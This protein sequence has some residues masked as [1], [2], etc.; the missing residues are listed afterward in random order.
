MKEL[1]LQLLFAAHKPEQSRELSLVY[2][3]LRCYLRSVCS[4][5]VEVGVLT[6]AVSVVYFTVFDQFRAR[7]QL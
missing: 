2:Y 4:I 1:L 6:I 5:S 7:I 3:S